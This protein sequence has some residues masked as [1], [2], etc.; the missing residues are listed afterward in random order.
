MKE[1]IVRIHF[2]KSKGSGYSSQVEYPG[3]NNITEK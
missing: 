3:Q 2:D 1:G